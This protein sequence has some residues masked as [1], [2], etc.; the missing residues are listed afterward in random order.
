MTGVFIIA[1]AGVN[2]NGSLAKAKQLVDIAAEAGADAV[3]FQTFSAERLATS[4]AAKAAYQTTNTGN[5][6]SQLEMLRALELSQHD[7]EELKAHCDLRGIEFMSTPFDIESVDM[8]VRQIGVRRL[9]VPSG[10]AVNGPLLLHV[11]RTGLPIILSTGMCELEEVLESLALLAWAAANDEGYPSSRAA[12]GETRKSEA[13]CHPLR[14]R[15]TVLHCVTQYPAAA[16]LTNLRALDL[17]HDVTG[18]AVG[19]SDHSL[20]SH[21]SVAAAARGAQVIEKHFTIS[22]ELPGPDHAASLE[23]PELSR[24]V[25]EIRE[26]ESALGRYEKTPQSIELA[27]RTAARGSLVATRPIRRGERFS[28]ENVSI[29]RAGGGVSPAAIWDYIGGRSATRDYA[30]DELIEDADK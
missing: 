13:W 10:E 5:G 6:G 14:D 8:L 15:V 28:L 3:K 26:V 11:W 22:R 9:K 4:S 19:L 2:H 17:L 12:I 7:H 20:G 29:K 18:L 30:A 25:R 23:A 16:E 24:M 27:N 21:I 1:E